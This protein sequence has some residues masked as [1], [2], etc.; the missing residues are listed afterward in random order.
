MATTP[1][2]EFEG[3]THIGEE[4][5]QIVE[6]MRVTVAGGRDQ[7]ALLVVALVIAAVTLTLGPVPWAQLGVGV[8]V[9]VT[10]RLGGMRT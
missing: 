7:S 10:W 6:A 3:R 8:L 2:E 4:A 5:R 9:W 1:E